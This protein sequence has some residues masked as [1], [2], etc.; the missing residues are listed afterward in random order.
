MDISILFC[1]GYNGG[2]NL[3][4]LGVCFSFTGVG[5]IKIMICG[6]KWTCVTILTSLRQLDTELK[7]YKI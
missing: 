4:N 3:T 5:P 6:Q 7:L 2:D 1:F